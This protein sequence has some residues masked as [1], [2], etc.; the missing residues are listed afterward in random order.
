MS[1]G[2][3][4]VKTEEAF[5]NAVEAGVLMLK[6]D[7]ARPPTVHTQPARCSGITKENFR[8]KVMVG[9]G[10]NGRY[11]TLTDPAVAK[12][13]WARVIVCGVCQRLDPAGAAAVDTAINDTPAGRVTRGS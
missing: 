3:T 7:T 6:T 10:K 2:L 13:Q 4:E 8:T 12:R 11:F 1:I 5:E 9:G